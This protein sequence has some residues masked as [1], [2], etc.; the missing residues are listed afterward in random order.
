[1]ATAGQSAVLAVNAGGSGLSYQWYRGA[2]GDTSQPIAGA[3]AATYS[4]PAMAATAHYWVRVRNA[5]GEVDSATFQL[6]LA[7]APSASIASAAASP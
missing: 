1:M 4:S 3:T 2:S 6:V 5:H 7:V